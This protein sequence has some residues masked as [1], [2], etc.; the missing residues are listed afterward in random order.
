MSHPTSCDST[1]PSVVEGVRMVDGDVACSG[2]ATDLEAEH[3]RAAADR[4]AV[5]E[6]ELADGVGRR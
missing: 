5:P 6:P 4:L 3:E 2:N 1:D